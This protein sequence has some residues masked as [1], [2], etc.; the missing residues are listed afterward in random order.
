[1][2]IALQAAADAF[3]R[4]ARIAAVPHAA[5]GLHPFDAARR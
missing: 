3:Y 1:M 5:S 2:L 4:H